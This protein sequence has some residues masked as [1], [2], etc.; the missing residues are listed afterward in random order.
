MSMIL[1]TPP[2]LE[3]VT[4]AEAKALLR[5]GH[6]DDDAEITTFITAAR[7]HSE[8]RTGLALITQV[9]SVYRDDWP[10]DGVVEL[11]LAPLVAV[12]AINV[13]GDDDV[14]AVVDAAHYYADLVSRPPRLLLRGSRVWASPG[15]IG[16]GIEIVVTAGYGATPSD[17]PEDLREAVLLLTAHWYGNR[18]AG[19][20]GMP[21]TVDTILS[22]YREVRL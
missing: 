9:W 22:R 13:Y 10:E 15:R 3:P 8:A 5:I 2:A 18:N 6:D 14:A 11:P 21:L 20:V 4:L 12:D 17:V 16:N 1:T 19:D 7:R